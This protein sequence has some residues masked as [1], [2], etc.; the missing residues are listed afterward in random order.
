MITHYETHGGNIVLVR[1]G[2]EMITVS[3]YTE[4]IIDLS[5]KILH[6]KDTVAR[7][8][9]EIE[10]YEELLDYAKKN[11]PDSVI[12]RHCKFCSPKDEI[13]GDCRPPAPDW[14][15]NAYKIVELV[16][17]ASDCQLFDRRKDD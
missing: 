15:K 11:L 9:A 10:R 3:S 2:S 17:D 13:N 16:R 8:K 1:N 12:C 4:L 5:N 6:R 14:M 7:L